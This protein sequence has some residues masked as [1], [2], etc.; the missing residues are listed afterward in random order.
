MTLDT[1]AQAHLLTLFQLCIPEN[2]VI[3]PDGM[4]RKY[5]E[6]VVKHPLATWQDLTVE[7]ARE[8]YKRLRA[9]HPTA[10]PPALS[11]AALAILDRVDR[12]QGLNRHDHAEVLVLINRELMHVT[13][14]MDR[15]DPCPYRLTE[16]GEAALRGRA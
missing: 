1:T 2:E 9:D 8:V 5:A 13:P 4:Y 14:E 6:R 11:A 7:E 15:S 10:L 12:R 3:P 16:A